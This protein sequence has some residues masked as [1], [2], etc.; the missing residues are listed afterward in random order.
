MID[1]F[2]TLQRKGSGTNSSIASDDVASVDSRGEPIL[3]RKGRD[4]EFEELL[5][6]YN[7]DEIEEKPKHFYSPFCNRW[8][9]ITGVSIVEAEMIHVQLQLH[10]LLILAVL[11]QSDNDVPDSLGILTAMYWTVFGHLVVCRS[12]CTQRDEPGHC[13]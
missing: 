9:S 13:C 11:C 12:H 3:E 10:F 7:V 4:E 2:A 8:I 6:K 1:K 5:E